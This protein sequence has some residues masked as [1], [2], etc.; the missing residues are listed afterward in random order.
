M[1]NLKKVLTSVGAAFL[2]VILM[3][4]ILQLMHITVGPWPGI[5]GAYVGY[6]VWSMMSSANTKD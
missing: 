2:V 6:L 3:S 1:N 5:L 4:M